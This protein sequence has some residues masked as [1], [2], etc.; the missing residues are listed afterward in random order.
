MKDT[1][2]IGARGQDVRVLQTALNA[3]GAELVV[4][5]I[6]GEK[7]AEEVRDFQI[8]ARLVADGIVGPKTWN[9]IDQALARK[10]HRDSLPKP[11]KTDEDLRRAGEEAVAIAL[12]WW[13]EDIYDPKPD[14]TS[15]AAAYSKAV[16]GSMITGSLGWTW[17]EPYVGDGDFEWC[18]AFAATCWGAVKPELRQ[19]CFASTYR[20]DRYG[21][22]RDVLGTSTGVRPATGP[23]RVREVVDGLNEAWSIAPRAGDILLV[24]K[25]GY[26][27]HICLVESFTAGTGVFN[28]IEGNAYGAGPNG[29]RQQGVIR[30]ERNLVEV[31][32]IIRPGVDDLI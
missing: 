21:A 14:D 8:G 31:R 6:F 7:T 24:G 2:R 9:E 4:D 32:R 16:I 19:L 17:E 3:L 10:K 26:G 13:Q 15:P 25:K 11:R 30:G 5:G 1:L 18:G 29:E 27:T 20:L 23:A 22:Y 28:T 12:R